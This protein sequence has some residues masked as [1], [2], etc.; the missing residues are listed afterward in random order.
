MN[1]RPSLRYKFL[2][3]LKLNYNQNLQYIFTQYCQN[4]NN[5]TD[6]KVGEKMNLDRGVHKTRTPT[7]PCVHIPK[8]LIS[9]V[10]QFKYGSIDT[11]TK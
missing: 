6:I 4:M 10:I 9:L 7:R 3:F 2:K 1:D 8:Y 11:N 5:L